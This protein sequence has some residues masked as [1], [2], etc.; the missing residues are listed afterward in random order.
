MTDISRLLCVSESSI[1][2]YLSVFQQTGD[3]KAVDYRHGPHSIL[4]YIIILRLIQE[5]LSIY[6]EEIRGKLLD[7]QV[8]QRYGERCIIRWAAVVKL[9]AT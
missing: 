5:R 1:R 6:L 3:V 7:S 2:G 8:L 9:F 4:E